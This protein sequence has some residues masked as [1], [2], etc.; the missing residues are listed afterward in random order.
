[1][2]LK[3]A[4]W[5]VWLHL[6]IVGGSLLQVMATRAV[7]VQTQPLR[8]YWSRTRVY[9]R[10]NMWLLQHVKA[11][12]WPLEPCFCTRRSSPSSRS[13]SPHL[14]KYLAPGHHPHRFEMSQLKPVK[15]VKHGQSRLALV[16]QAAIEVIELTQSGLSFCFLNNLNCLNRWDPAAQSCV[17]LPPLRVH[18]HLRRAVDSVFLAYLPHALSKTSCL[19]KPCC[20]DP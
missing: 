16:T 18:S 10:L 13:A 20:A 15:H 9:V 11:S 17:S 19:S 6:A 5:D 4:T 2:S 14:L 12:C 1:M 3:H 8:M 7:Y